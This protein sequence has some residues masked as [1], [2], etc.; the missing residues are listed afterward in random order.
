MLGRSPCGRTTGQTEATTILTPGGKADLKRYMQM[1][2]AGLLWMTMLAA[3]DVD[4]E[5][6][7]VD[8]IEYKRVVAALGAAVAQLDDRSR[9]VLDALHERGLTLG[10]T[11]ALIGKSERHVSRIH[12]RARERLARALERAGITDF[13]EQ[14]GRAPLESARK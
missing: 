7:I 11:T 9:V 12:V 14:R 2:A 4:P 3:K 5:A 10:E 8:H 6:R 13:P 1:R